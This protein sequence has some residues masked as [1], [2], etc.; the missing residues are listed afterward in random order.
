MM[1]THQNVHHNKE[2]F[3]LG[4][5]SYGEAWLRTTDMANVI[6]MLTRGH[7]TLPGRSLLV[8]WWSSGLDLWGLFS[9]LNRVYL[10]QQSVCEDRLC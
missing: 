9:L 3:V 8:L 7:V 10:G 1:L 6:S 4:L 5:S 2:S